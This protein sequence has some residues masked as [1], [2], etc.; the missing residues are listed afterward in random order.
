MLFVMIEYLEERRSGD[1]DLNDELMHF[2]TKGM[3]W[4]FRHQP[5]RTEKRPSSIGVPK[6]I[7]RGS[8]HFYKKRALASAGAALATRAA[9]K[10]LIG[11]GKHHVFKNP[12]TAMAYNLGVH[13]LGAAHLLSLAGAAKY[14]GQYAMTKISPGYTRN[15]MKK[16]SNKKPLLG[17][18]QHVSTTPGVDAH[19]YANRAKKRA[20]RAVAGTALEY[21]S[22]TPIINA[23]SKS[24]NNGN[25]GKAGAYLGA[26]YALNAFTIYNTVG[27]IADAIRARRAVRSGKE[28]KKK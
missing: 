6:E 1:G 4:G 5:T 18:R 25:I 27:G 14:G 16:Y 9:G 21:A 19:F 3:R 8:S 23:A 2:G 10:A 26:A 17:P 13:G 7:A 24:F 15:Q 22:R 11:Y 12:R 28:K 20:I